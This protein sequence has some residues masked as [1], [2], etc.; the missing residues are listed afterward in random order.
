MSILLQLGFIGLI[1]AIIVAAILRRSPK[2]IDMNCHCASEY[3]L[4]AGHRRF[5]SDGTRDP[6][7]VALRV[8][9]ARRWLAVGA[10]LKCGRCGG[11]RADD[12]SHVDARL[13]RLEDN[14]N[15]VANET[16]RSSE[17]V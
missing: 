4:D 13:A 5:S 2:K 9:A 16:L 6:R 17:I 15:D 7:V 8:R 3:R 11:N 1:I 12:A 14:I 10:N